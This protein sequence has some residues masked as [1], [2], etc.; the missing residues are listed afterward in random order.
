VIVAGHP[1][2]NLYAKHASARESLFHS[3]DRADLS[4]L[5]TSLVFELRRIV[6]GDDTLLVSD[7]LAVEV[8]P[9]GRRVTERCYRVG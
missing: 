9:R 3:D 1:S 4:R 7:T 2:S 8:G 5:R 6:F